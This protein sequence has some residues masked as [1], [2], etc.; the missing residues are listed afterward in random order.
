MKTVDDFISSV[1]RNLVENRAK[2]EEWDLSGVMQWDFRE[3]TGEQFH[4]VLTP[5][6]FQVVMGA[7]PSPDFIVVAPFQYFSRMVTGEIDHDE[8]VR[9]GMI[10]P[11]GDLNFGEKFSLLYRSIL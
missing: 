11:V 8:A 10:K 5:G 4:L 7:H 6:A 2:V 1:R 9:S 3:D